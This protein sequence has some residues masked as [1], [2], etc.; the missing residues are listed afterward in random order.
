MRKYLSAGD[1]SIR[2]LCNFSNMENILSYPV[3]LYTKF[4]LF[5]NYFSNMG[6]TEKCCIF[7]FEI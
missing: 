5:G 4:I 2:I 3:K 6:K 1:Y 7:N